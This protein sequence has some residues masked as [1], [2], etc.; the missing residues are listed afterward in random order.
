M[1]ESDGSFVNKASYA[2]VI[3]N[4]SPRFFSL[5]FYFRL[6]IFES[7]FTKLQ[8]NID[9]NRRELL[10]YSTMSLLVCIK[11]SYTSARLFSVLL[12]VLVH[13]SMLSSANATGYVMVFRVTNIIFKIKLQIILYQTVFIQLL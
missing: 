5:K 10:T 11:W 9:L 1:C 4:F 2:T 13:I 6:Y 8:I 7:N 3:C 12:V